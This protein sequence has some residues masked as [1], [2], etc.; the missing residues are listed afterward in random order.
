M[1]KAT[2]VRLQ[3]F[4]H[5]IL[6]PYDPEESRSAKLISTKPVHLRFMRPLTILPRHVEKVFCI[7]AFTSSFEWVV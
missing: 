3:S 4:F 6:T 5:K 7:R 2:E 1:T